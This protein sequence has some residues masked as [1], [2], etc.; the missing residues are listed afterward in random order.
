MNVLF[1][2]QFYPPDVAPT[3][4]YLHDVARELTMRGHYVTVVCSRRN[5]DGGISYVREHALDGVRVLR[6]AACGFGRR[7][8][9]GKLLDYV[10]FYVAAGWALAT[11]RCG[12][13]GGPRGGGKP[14][15]VVALST[16]PL[17][18]VLARLAAWLRR[19]RHAHWIMDVYPD[20]LAA[21][22]L[23]VRGGWLYRAI[24]WL[25]RR[26]LQGSALVLT[27]GPSMA[28][29]LVSKLSAPVEWVPLWSTVPLASVPERAGSGTLLMYSGNM[30][31]GH[32]I[33]DLLEAAERLSPSKQ[34]AWLFVGGGRR[35]VQ[36]EAW[37]AAHPNANVGLQRYAPAEELA[38]HLQRADV[39][40]VSLAA[41]WQGC[42]VPSK[43]QNIFASGRPAVFV[44]GVDNELAR[45]IKE[46]DAGWVV[47]E[48]NVDGLLQAIEAA[49]EPAVRRSKGLAARR[50]AAAHFDP[51][52]NI[53]RV[54]ALIEKA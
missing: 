1:I 45:W 54:C 53:A 12:E 38:S 15:I 5:Y 35:R 33:G 24:D 42:M 23:L 28:R 2:N 51:V 9:V 19:C 49:C 41:S 10:T 13:E 4:C 25:A 40:L 14:D 34:V 16:P 32:R 37:K 8:F 31:L 20:V 11:V 50:F 6:V 17:I 30:G 47:A 3:G 48:G 27:L 22:G 36:V 44:G 7:S 43:I 52:E 18:G 26:E 21:H 46:A 39:H 29:R